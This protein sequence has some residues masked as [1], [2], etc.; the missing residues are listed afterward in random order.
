MNQATIDCLPTIF[1]EEAKLKSNI[2]A[3]T[4][5]MYSYFNT[6][7]IKLKYR[8]ETVIRLSTRERLL[9]AKGNLNY[10]NRIDPL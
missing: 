3:A 7:L 5:C 1:K 9:V 6:D 10:D 4:N 8:E 2:H